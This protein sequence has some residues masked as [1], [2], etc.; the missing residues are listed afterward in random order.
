[1][2]YITLNKQ[3]FFHNLNI[4]L[5]KTKSKDKI[6]I[7]LKD[8]AYGHGL[9]EIASLSKEYGLTKAIVQTEAEAK[10]VEKFFEYILILADIPT[11]FN[12]KFRYT[13][14]DLQ[15]IKMFPKKTKV[16]LKVDSGMHRNGVIFEELE[17]A[18]KEIDSYGLDLEAVFTHHRSADL[19]TSEWFWQNEN[20]KKIK[21]KVK[22]LT[23]TYN[24]K[25]PRFHSSA[26]ASLFRTNE[27]DEDM[28][29]I[30]IGA[31]GCAD[32][33]GLKPVL[34]LYANKLSSRLVKKGQMIGYG[35]SYTAEKDNVVST[36]D[37]GYGAGFLRI[38]SN[39]FITPDGYKQVGRISMDNS[40][41]LSD[42]ESI[43]IFDD[44]SK[45]AHNANTIS[46]EI[47]TSLKDNLKK[48][49]I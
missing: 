34:S 43:L 17:D 29:R 11:T 3:N 22:A 15:T 9:V 26:S 7:V 30:G 4:I 27:F 32:I 46:Y 10:I 40:A 37:I 13:I 33:D 36:Y 31:Y 42:K 2:A 1:M 6:A 39:N 12:P 8:N 18:Y 19:L 49:I 45:I 21:L 20:F 38:F 25:L 28:A 47:L 5:S 44:A 48:V 35:A 23:K 16:E 14:N 41:F 24:F